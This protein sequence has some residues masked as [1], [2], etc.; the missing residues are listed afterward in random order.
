LAAAR[1][2]LERHRGRAETSAA[3]GAAGALAG[4]GWP[5]AES[6]F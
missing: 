4:C 6:M 5:A 2:E 1:A 3:L